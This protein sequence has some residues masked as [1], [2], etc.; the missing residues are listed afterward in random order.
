[1]PNKLSLHI[2]SSRGAIFRECM[3]EFWLDCQ[4]SAWSR[5]IDSGLKC[6][7]IFSV[8]RPAFKFSSFI[9]GVTYMLG[10]KFFMVK[11][12]VI[13][14]LSWSGNVEISQMG[15]MNIST[16]HWPFDIEKNMCKISGHINHTRK[17]EIPYTATVVSHYICV[18]CIFH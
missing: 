7:Q 15:K 8:I 18:R 12:M 17:T 14:M 6:L 4:W 3:F 9:Y 2:T 10:V 1:V 11:C 5:Y 16:L 13:V